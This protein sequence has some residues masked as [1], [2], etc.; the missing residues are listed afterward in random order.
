MSMD[1]DWI[2]ADL[3]RA[4]SSLEQKVSDLEDRIEEPHTPEY[5]CLDDVLGGEFFEDDRGVAYMRVAND[6]ACRS[7]SKVNAVSANGELRTFHRKTFNVRLS[8]AEVFLSQR[9]K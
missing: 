1:H 6:E 4:I 2:I 8:S 7:W 5:T 3:Q 9:E